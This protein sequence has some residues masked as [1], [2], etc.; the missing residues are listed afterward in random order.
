MNRTMKL[1]PELE[2]YELQLAHNAMKDMNDD[3]A[4]AFA[5]IYRTRRKDPQT[6]L[7]LCLVGLFFIPG[8]QR[9]FMDQMGMGLLYLFTLGLCFIGSL[10]DIVNYRK[11]AEEYNTLA[12]SRVLSAMQTV[13]N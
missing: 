10:V 8:I 3:D 4:Q 1:L 7:V 2:S 6:V 9:F 5:N 12:M 11:L 13:N